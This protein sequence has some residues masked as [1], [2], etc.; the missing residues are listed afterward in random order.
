MASFVWWYIVI[1]L[2]GALLIWAVALLAL[3]RK[4]RRSNVGSGLNLA[5]FSIM[6]PE[7]R[8]GQGN[9]EEQLKHFIAQMEQF[10]A[11]LATIRRSGVSSRLLGHPIFALEI[12]AH[13]K[14]D[15]VFF[16]VAFPRVYIS[17]LRNQLHGAFPDAHIEQVPDYNIFHP[18]GAS[19]VGV[20]RQADSQLLPTK[21]YRTLAVD[22]LETITSAF[23]KLK[24]VGLCYCNAQRRKVAQLRVW[25]KIHNQ[26]DCLDFIVF[27]KSRS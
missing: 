27:K 12:A 16:Y 1:A 2:G 22:P 10:L 3:V 14:G 20:L 15:D 11:G 13:N 9:P 21:T 26:R 8:I 5:L 19:A 18:E 25:Q 6:V 4:K 23:S 24:E 7:V 17:V